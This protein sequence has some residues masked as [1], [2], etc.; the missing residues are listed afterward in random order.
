MILTSVHRHTVCGFK[1]FTSCLNVIEYGRS[2][3]P[4]FYYYGI[5]VFVISPCISEITRLDQVLFII[6]HR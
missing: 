2:S 5:I 6:I 1:D 3:N 4:M